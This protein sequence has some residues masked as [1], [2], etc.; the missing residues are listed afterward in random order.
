M[1]ICRCRSLTNRIF[2]VVALKHL[3]SNNVLDVAWETLVGSE[4]V[5]DSGSVSIERGDLRLALE[6]AMGALTVA[7]WQHRIRFVDKESGAW[8]DWGE[9][10]DGHASDQLKASCNKGF[11]QYDERPLYAAPPEAEIAGASLSPEPDANRRPHWD[12]D[13][14]WSEHDGFPREDWMYEV[15]NGDTVSGYIDWVNNQIEIQRNE[16]P[17]EIDY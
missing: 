8:A 15:A 16:P 4:V 7:T 5:D 9:W 17:H 12:P 14:I 10:Q 2:E 6:A 1:Q 11:G 13:D 3:L